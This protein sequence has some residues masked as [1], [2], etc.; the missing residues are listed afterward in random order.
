MATGPVLKAWEDLRTLDHQ[1][2]GKA[3]AGTS[4]AAEKSL[5]GQDNQ[6]N[7]TAVFNPHTPKYSVNP[8]SVGSASLH[9]KTLAF[10]EFTFKN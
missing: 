8:C 7:E 2:A 5:K 1:S 6:V 10:T 4:L 3:T 9:G